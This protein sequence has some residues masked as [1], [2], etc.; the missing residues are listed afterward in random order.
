MARDERLEGTEAEA[1]LAGA[2]AL[3]RDA[4]VSDM[5]FEFAVRALEAALAERPVLPAPTLAFDLAVLLSGER[6]Q[7]VAAPTEDA[8]KDALRQY[9]D[10][11][12]ARLVSE[13]R[14]TPLMEAVAAS[15]KGLKA[16]AVGMTVAMVLQRVA[17]VGGTGL[18]SG[19]VRRLAQKAPLEI[20]DGGRAA[21]HQPE[22]AARLADGLLLLARAARRSRELLSDAEIFV[23]ENL[24]ALK[25]LGPRVALAQLAE[26]AQA[27]DEKLPAR[28][29]GHAFEDGEAP[30]A[31]EEDSAYPVGG[32][33]SISTSGS[34][35][36]LV[37]SELIYM[38]QGEAE[39]L[40]PDLFDVR[41]VE[42]EL[43]YYARDESVAVRKKRA[44]VLV[45]DGSLARARVLDGGERYQRLVWALGSV[46]ALVR[47]LSQWLDTEALR[48]E[49][50]FPSQKGEQPLAEERGVVELLLREYRERGQLDVMDAPDTL[51]AV[52]RARD[53]HGGRARVMLFAARMPSGLEGPAAP[54]AILELG[55]PRPQ[56]HWHDA[57]APAHEA[58]KD[59]L[60]AWAGTTK[61]LLDG[62]LTRRR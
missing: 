42:N 58:P 31:L 22:V 18:S 9:E 17:L 55:G 48:F 44:L 60:E 20:L 50:V 11:V 10:H 39:H 38:E 4:V 29:R 19:V 53:V 33:S 47:K 21:L 59:A 26:V 23:V 49:L 25:G 5:H 28:L 15:P 24:A 45:F 46:T 27:V 61:Q 3:S 54:D 8:L 35:E 13:R 36:N 6:L 16:A 1:F 34:L 14:W 7:P 51:G 62:L 57:A 40:R 30:T 2:V 52:E 12:L 43:L 41:F 37:T 32:F 56:V